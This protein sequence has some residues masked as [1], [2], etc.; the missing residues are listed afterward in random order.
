MKSISEIL[1]AFKTGDISL[2]DAQA[3]IESSGVVDI[4]HTR[5][6]V[7]RRSRTGVGEVVY[8]AGKTKGQIL[9]IIRKI[10]D[11]G[12]NTLV[13]R[14][15][16]E[17][18]D[19]ISAEFP[20]ARA[21][22]IARTVSIVSDAGKP[23]HSGGLVAIVTAGTS[24]MYVAEEARET[25]NFLGDNVKTFYDCGVAGL[26][27]ILSVADEIRKA[28]AVI[29]IAGMEGALA[30]VAAGL[31]KVPVIAVPTSVGYGASFGGLAALLS[32]INSCANG[33]SEVNI[34]NGFGAAYIAHLI[35]SI[36][37]R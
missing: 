36:K 26:H 23:A 1:E 18:S 6:D 32:M 37:D 21:N 19:A 9:D 2:K 11:M 24:D 7:G 28:N 4:S 22:E 31:L 17:I 15:S 10:V 27:R 13:T 30:S 33:V 14:V 35:N 3:A 20:Q 29:A 12:E 5:L 34:D 25:L 16:K 8:G